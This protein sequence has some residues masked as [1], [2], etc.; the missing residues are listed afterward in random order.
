M[1][2]RRQAIALGVSSGVLPFVSKMSRAQTPAK[3]IRLM[4]WG[5][6]W[7]DIFRPVAEAFEKDTGTKVE[8]IVQSGAA[9]GLNKL[10]A[11]KANPQVDVWTSISS[12]MQVATK[13]GLLA[14]LDAGKIPQLAEMPKQFVGPT[15]ASIW[16]SPRGIFYRTDL[17]PFE[18]KD[19]KDL[20]DPRLKDKVGVTM[21]LD[22]GSFL[23]VSALLN[24]GDEH[25][26]DKGFENLQKLK[27][28]IHTVYSTDPESIKLLETG[29]VAVIAWGA[30]PNVYRHLGPDSKYRFVM[31]APH[32]LADIP[33]SIVKGRGDA[34]Q[35]AAEKFV[36]YM[37]Q[38]KYQ[39]IMASIAGTVPANPEAAVPEK[40]R[41]IIPKLP[42]PDVYSVDW[43]TVNTQY[44]MWEDRWARE[45]QVR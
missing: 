45:V 8:F 30:L 20:W 37:L 31:P 21:A 44:S 36:D 18:L 38:P 17:S 35:A 23:I 42:I 12:T 27:P 43:T 4:T 40:L 5:G 19:W 33:V 34:Q 10:T 28:N 26:I 9:D 32:F 41:G 6:S 29:E 24:G 22:R 16:L 39:T 11:Q 15:G 7:Q 3:V 13:A 2:N 25:K 14:N 1:L